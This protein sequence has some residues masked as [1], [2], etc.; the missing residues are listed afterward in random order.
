MKYRHNKCLLS[1]F[2][3]PFTPWL[4][5]HVSPSF[6]G[7][8]SPLSVSLSCPLASCWSPDFR[9]LFFNPYFVLINFAS[10]V[11]LMLSRSCSRTHIHART[12]T[13]VWM[14][15]VTE[16]EGVSTIL[17]SVGFDLFHLLLSHISGPPAGWTREGGRR[18]DTVWARWSFPTPPSQL[19]IP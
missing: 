16:W 3:P 7:S 5:L 11:T 9:I 13:H 14:V 18:T 4:L 19:V 17:R 8:F 1:L 10:W 6:T 12:H 15:C 2:L